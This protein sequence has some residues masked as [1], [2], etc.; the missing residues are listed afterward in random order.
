MPEKHCHYQPILS[1]QPGGGGVVGWW[2]GRGEKER[3]MGRKQSYREEKAI[4]PHSQFSGSIT[5]S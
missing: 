4:N 3:A 2:G 1:V 5:N